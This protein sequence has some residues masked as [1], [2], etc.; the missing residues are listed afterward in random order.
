MAEK[1]K[2][3][4]IENFKRRRKIEINFYLLFCKSDYF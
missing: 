1:L 3:T 2:S 4:D